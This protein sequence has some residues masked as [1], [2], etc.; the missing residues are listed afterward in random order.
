MITELLSNLKDGARSNKYKV[1][2]PFD[3]EDLNILVQTAT[4]PGRTITPIEIY[5]R[6]RK[7]QLRGET[8]LENTIDISFY[9]TTDMKAR[10]QII[11]WMMIV[12]N[13]QYIPGGS[14]FGQIGSALTSIVSGVKNIIN[15]PT[16]LLSSGGNP[17]QKDITIEQLNGN[18]DVSYSATLIGAFPINV[19][20]IE[21]DDSN[22][23][24]TKT[25]VSF[26][27]TEVSENR[28]GKTSVQDV[29]SAFR[30]I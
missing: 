12:H 7:V 10:K 6:G 26:A 14:A 5:L 30:G 29:L 8:N 17:Y 9:N 18:G 20:T 11:D 22:S 21:Y 19:S 24:I 4:F 2:I 1:N 15:D 25:T 3:D 16:S 13:N 23:E 28:T 27:F